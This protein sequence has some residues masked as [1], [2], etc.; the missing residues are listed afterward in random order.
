[1]PRD[2]ILIF[3]VLSVSSGSVPGCLIAAIAALI[4][5]VYCYFNHPSPSQE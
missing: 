3:L 1:M 4:F 2:S 5:E